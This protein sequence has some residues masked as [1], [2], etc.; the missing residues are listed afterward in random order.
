MQRVL[1]CL[2]RAHYRACLST[3]YGCGLRLQEGASLQVSNI[4]SGR[5]LLHVR[6]GKGNKD[7][8][9]PLPDRILE[10]LREHWLTHR[11]RVWLFPGRG[12]R[13]QIVP[14][15]PKPLSGRGIEFAFTSALKESGLHKPATVHTLR[16]SYATHLLE[17]G[18]NIRLIQSYLGHNSL[19]STAFYTHLTHKTKTGAVETINRVIEA[20][21]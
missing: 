6:K 17:A 20:V 16:H 9:V 15:A 12:R 1:S 4:D 8:Y 21:V 3:I 13:G 14:N 2:Q 10:L 7:R 5:K 11:H 18:V 19:S